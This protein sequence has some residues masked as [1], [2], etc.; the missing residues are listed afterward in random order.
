MRTLLALV[1]GVLMPSRGR[2]LA[3]A[4]APGTSTTPAVDRSPV[5]AAPAADDLR[6]E[7]AALVRPYV[8]AWEQHVARELEGVW[9]RERLEAASLAATRGEFLGVPA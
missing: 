1:L 4:P 2:H 3:K 5:P 7:D 9:R 6:G 8:V